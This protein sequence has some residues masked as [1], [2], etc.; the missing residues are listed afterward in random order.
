MTTIFSKILQ[1]L[2]SIKSKPK[3]SP[4]IIDLK[5]FKTNSN[6][7]LR[8]WFVWLMI[9]SPT[10]RKSS[11]P[12]SKWSI[13]STGS[14]KDKETPNY[15]KNSLRRPRKF[16]MIWISCTNICKPTSHCTSSS[17]FRKLWTLLWRVSS[18]EFYVYTRRRDLRNYTTIYWWTT[19]ARCK[20]WCQRIATIFGK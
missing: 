20:I 4:S 5:I 8:T 13:L 10:M 19:L 3:W 15:H 7:S 11:K 18:V 17:K 9:P 2:Q 6:G 14:R 16:K 1:G 12:N